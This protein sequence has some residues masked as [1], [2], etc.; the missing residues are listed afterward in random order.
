MNRPTLRGFVS[1]FLLV[2]FVCAACGV[3]AADWPCWHGANRNGLSSETGLLRTWDENTFASPCWKNTTI[4]QTM[5]GVAV[6]GN[7][8]Y[9]IGTKGGAECVFLIDNETGKTIRST[10]I[11]KAGG[12]K[13]KFPVQR[14]TPTFY[15]DRIYAVSSGG[16]VVAMMAGNLA[17]IWTRN[18]VT[19]MGGVLPQGGYCE[20]PYIDGKWAIVCPGG[21][22][23]SMVAVDRHWGAN[24]WIANAGMCAGY[25][26]MMKASFGREHQYVSFSADG[27]FGVKVRGK[28]QVRWRYDGSAHESG[29]NPVPPIWFGQTLLTSSA[30]GTGC[31]WVQKDGDAFKTTEVWFDEK[32]KIPAGEMLKVNDCVYACNDEYGL[33]C[34]DYKTGKVLWTDKSLFA[35]AF[36]EEIDESKTRK[37]RKT[38]SLD[39]VPESVAVN[40]P[41]MAQ[42]IMPPMGMQGPGPIAPAGKNMKK[43]KKVAP[44]EVP[45]C[46]GSMTYAEGLIYLRT[47]MGEL[48]LLEASRDKC[49]IRGRITAEQIPQ[50]RPGLAVTPVIANGYLYLR[51]GGTLYCFDIRDKS[52]KE[53]SKNPDDASKNGGGNGSKPLPGMPD[54]PN[55]KR[56]PGPS[57]G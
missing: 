10:P 19:T 48:V 23:A 22:A 26:S 50:M 49:I 25:T 7:L 14:S 2:V 13:S 20:S 8:V 27:L 39:P 9:T 37:T 31:I 43:K 41:L 30:A 46:M 44:P 52:R 6:V 4:G 55:K 24:A 47:S 56:R 16:N 11:G 42:I 3:Q 15:K 12:G 45:K 36:E 40:S 54:S 17:P 18:M 35:E 28:G 1:T 51:E 57:V 34:F 53:G 29:Y 38:S 32:L 33:F 5:N 21:P